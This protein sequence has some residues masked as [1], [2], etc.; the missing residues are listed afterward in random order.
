MFCLCKPIWCLHIKGFCCPCLESEEDHLTRIAELSLKTIPI[1][2]YRRIKTNPVQDNKGWF[3]PGGVLPACGA[4]DDPNTEGGLK[5][6][7]AANP[8]LSCYV[9]ID[10]TLD[11]F[12][13]SAG[14]SLCMTSMQFNFVDDDDLS[15]SNGENA[16]AY[17]NKPSVMNKLIPLRDISHVSCGNDDDWNELGIEDFHVCGIIAHGV[18]KKDRQDVPG[19]K[20]LIFNVVKGTKQHSLRRDEVAQHLNT[21]VSWNRRRSAKIEPKKDEKSLTTDNAPQSYALMEDGEDVQDG[22]N[23]SKRSLSARRSKQGR[24]LTACSVEISE[25]TEGYESEA[26]VNSVSATMC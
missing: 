20:I 16:K 18:P 1:K 6:N 12:D 10:A 13:T 4:L 22:K 19:R 2:W 5:Q 26:K 9:G 17:G 23:I 21:L 24:E 7:D 3:S 11:V 14:P 15:I 8:E 25:S